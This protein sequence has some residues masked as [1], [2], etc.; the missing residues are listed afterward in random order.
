MNDIISILGVR[1]ELVPIHRDKLRGLNADMLLRFSYYTVTFHHQ[2]ICVVQAKNQETYTPLKYK[3]MTEQ[4][5]TV[6]AMPVAVLLD[7]L[8]FYE[9]E[10]LISQGVYY[11]ISDKYAFLPSLIANVRTKKQSKN[12][13]RLIPAAQYIL[14]YHLSADTSDEFTIRELQKIMPY[15]YLAISRAVINLEECRLCQTKKDNSGAKIILFDC[16]K[17]EL[18]SKSQKYLSSPVKKILYSDSMPEG[19]FSVCGV[20][21]LSYYSHLN[22]EQHSTMAI[23]DRS[24]NANAQYNDIEGVFRIEV[25]KYPTSMPCQPDGKV[26]NKLSLYLSMKDEP[27]ARIEKELE[28]LIEEM[29]W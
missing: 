24:L 26:V 28:I 19:D 29:K 1:V 3:R 22:P 23:W 20:N 10:R 15:N 2:S 7:T 11:I 14:L 4:I 12:Q 8:A 16:P 6:V 27:D 13:D 5:E 17:R 25:W 18:W 9:R 21:A